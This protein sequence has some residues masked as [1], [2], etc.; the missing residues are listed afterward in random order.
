[1]E[2]LSSIYRDTATVLPL[3]HWPYTMMSSEFRETTHFLY[4]GSDMKELGPIVV[5]SQ[6][7]TIHFSDYAVPK[8]WKEIVLGVKKHCF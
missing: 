8:P 6:V 3:P 4:L 5:M 7:R 1:M 2:L